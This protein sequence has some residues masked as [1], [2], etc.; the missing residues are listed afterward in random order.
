MPWRLEGNMSD[1]Q[2][3]AALIRPSAE[4]EFEP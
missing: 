4:A 3:I 2:R 1:L